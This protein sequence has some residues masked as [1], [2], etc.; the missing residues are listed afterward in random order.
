MSLTMTENTR[1]LDLSKDE[2]STGKIMCGQLGRDCELSDA[3]FASE[4]SQQCLWHTKRCSNPPKVA[5]KSADCGFWCSRLVISKC[6]DNKFQNAL[7]KYPSNNFKKCFPKNIFQ[8]ALP[9]YPNALLFSI[10]RCPSMPVY[11]LPNSLPNS[12]LDMMRVKKD[13]PFQTLQ[14]LSFFGRACPSVLNSKQI[15]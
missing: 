15:I 12:L 10:T 7:P 5:L 11:A 9:N 8:K 2:T 13:M 4:D 1:Q 6:S 3:T 14:Y